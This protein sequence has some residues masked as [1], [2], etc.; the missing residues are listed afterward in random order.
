MSRY[1]N[2][3]QVMKQL[4]GE[5]GLTQPVSISTSDDVQAIQLLAL[6]NSSG[7]E[8]MLYYPWEQFHKEW[9][10]NT[11]IDKGEY[12]LPADWNYAIDQTQWDRT[13]HWP[14]L[15]PK[16]AQE[17]AWL[18]GGLL[19]M[20]PRLRFR[21][22][23]NLFKLWPIPSTATSPSQYTLSQEYITRNWVLGQS[24]EGAPIDTDMAAKDTDILYYDP[25][26]LVKFV[27]MKF[28]ELK[29]FDTTSTQAEF[30]RIFNTLTGKDV[31][32][33]ILN[34]APRPLSQYIGPWSVPDGNWNVGQP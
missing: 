6:L 28:Y 18:K 4:T 16:S 8:L 23:E 14:L 19:A 33:P 31:G 15:G 17:W 26:L 5:L 20:A 34:L 10:F 9:V 21:I 22:Q 32:A 25:W 27:K 24:A 2:A 30:M 7:N 12:E 29:G 11:E 1:W 13:D 3:L